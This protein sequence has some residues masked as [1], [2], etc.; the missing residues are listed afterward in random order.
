MDGPRDYHTIKSNREKQVSYDIT[1]MWNLIKM[2]Q[3]SLFV[4]QKQTQISKSKQL[5]G[6]PVMAQQQRTQLVTMRMWVQSLASLSG[7][8]IQHCHEL[9]YRLQTLLRS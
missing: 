9:W 4:K 2:I 3:M 5:S 1:Y 8:S 6:I 7:L